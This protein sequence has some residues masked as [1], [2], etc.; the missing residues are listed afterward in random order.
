MRRPTPLR[1]A[2]SRTAP[3]VSA[4][5]ATALLLTACG[6][7][8]AGTAA[9]ASP[10]RTRVDDAGKDGVRITWLTLPAATPTPSP[11]R[12]HPVAAETLTF[13]TDSG[14]SAEYEVTNASAAALTYSITFTFMS[15]DGGSMGNPTATVRD[16][17]PGK[18]VRGTVRA[19]ILP[20]GTPRVTRAKVSTVTAVPA[21]EAPAAPGACPA[22]GIK[23]SAD[24][25]DA[26]MGLRVVGLHLDNCGKRDY[27]V[28][29][30]PLLTLLDDDRKP[31][32][33]IAILNGSREI[34]SSAGDDK[35][36]RAITLKPGESATAAL[37]WRNT[38]QSGT[39]VNVPYVQVR[40][41]AGAAPVTVTPNLDLG[42]TGQLGVRPWEKV[43][44]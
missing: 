3:F 16:V 30:Y 44:R 12:S 31:V 42:T 6:T 2:P 37:V 43:Q 35:P 13:P 25:G 27:T 18:T 14:I 5:A 19:G 32:T 11:T 10:S 24:Q 4:L 26:A 20:P 39:A 23:V 29:G 34:T 17:G 1:L 38:T 9:T 28:Q 22:S 21:S 33:G 7:Q 41:K 15:A 8:H 40:A 36:P